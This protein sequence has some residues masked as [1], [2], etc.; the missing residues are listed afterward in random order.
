MKA[1]ADNG[2]IRG[3]RTSLP[4]REDEMRTT[5]SPSRRSLRWWCDP[6]GQPPEPSSTSCISRSW[7]KGCAD[8]DLPRVCVKKAQARRVT[9]ARG[10][11][12]FPKPTPLS[13][14]RD[15]G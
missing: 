9:G 11:W 1:V 10:V 3:D 6:P 15:D 14:S 13:R 2:E 12:R 5:A 7:P 4:G 8:P